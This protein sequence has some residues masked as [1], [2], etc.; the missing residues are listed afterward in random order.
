MFKKF[1]FGRNHVIAGIFALIIFIT[2]VSMIIINYNE[3]L[4]ESY[5][6]SER[7][8]PERTKIGMFQAAWQQYT[9]N[10]PKKVTQAEAV[11]AESTVKSIYNFMFG[12]DAILII[13]AGVVILQPIILK[14]IKDKSK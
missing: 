1:K 11:R 2:G 12:A 6:A 14:R 5:E 3:S 10:T 13:A 8:L 9:G 4:I 7:I